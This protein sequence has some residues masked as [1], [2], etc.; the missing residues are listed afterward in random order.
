[1]AQWIIETLGDYRIIGGIFVSVGLLV[2]CRKSRRTVDTSQEGRETRSSSEEDS[3]L[4]K[5]ES[6]SSSAS[7]FADDSTEVYIKRLKYDSM[8]KYVKDW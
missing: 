7:A 8:N 1:M 4:M 5:S 6:C 2:L 3:H